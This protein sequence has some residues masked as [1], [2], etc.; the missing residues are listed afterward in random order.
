MKPLLFYSKTADHTEDCRHR[1]YLEKI[2]KIAVETYFVFE[3]RNDYDHKHIPEY[4]PGTDILMPETCWC[5]I[6]DAN[7]AWPQLYFSPER[8]D[9]WK[10]KSRFVAA[11]DDI[12]TLSLRD[13]HEKF[14]TNISGPGPWEV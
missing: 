13:I 6:P 1:E 5:D 7:N 12:L 3:H 10:G 2:F 11:G 9:S 4:F 14:G 8:T